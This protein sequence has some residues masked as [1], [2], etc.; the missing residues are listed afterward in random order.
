M[1]FKTIALAALAAVA[2]PSF[3]FVQTG[4]EIGD[5][6]YVLV[7]TNATG[8]YFQDLGVSTNSLASLLN[9]TGNFAQAV[10]GAEYT[11]FLNFG[12]VNTQWSIIAVQP[13]ADGFSPGEINAWSTVNA[14]QALGKIENAQ[15]NNSSA[16]LAGQYLR[17]DNASSPKVENNTKA[18]A[19]GATAYIA[20]GYLFSQ[21]FNARNTVGASA[22]MV[23]MTTSSDVSDEAA[24]YEVLKNTSGSAYVASF[25]GA[26]VS[27]TAAVT[28]A[29]PEPSTYAMLAAGLAAVGFMARRRKA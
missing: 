26:N 19:V 21:Y 15:F 24:Y 2:A 1:K 20:N 27:I 14:S 3:A 10:G 28:P 8:S 12:G 25:D 17:N 6:E 7:A 9:T 4:G 16:L 29:V 23:Y 13:L 22:E 18:I 5:A 11:K